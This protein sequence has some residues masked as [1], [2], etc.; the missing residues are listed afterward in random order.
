MKGKIQIKNVEIFLH[1]F[2]N[3]PITYPC[4]F[5]HGLILKVHNLAVS[6]KNKNKNEEKQQRLFSKLALRSLMNSN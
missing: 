4:F 2:H 6:C 3:K 1:M 5:I